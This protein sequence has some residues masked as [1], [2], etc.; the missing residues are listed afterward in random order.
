MLSVLASYATP[1]YPWYGHQINPDKGPRT[2]NAT[3]APL[4]AAAEDACGEH[5]PNVC[6]VQYDDRPLASRPEVDNGL[7]NHNEK[8]C[9]ALSCCTYVFK[10]ATSTEYAPYWAKVAAVAEVLNGTSTRCDYAYW[11][12]ADAALNPATNTQ[13]LIDI[14]GTQDMVVAPD[15]PCLP[16]TLAID[17]G[18]CDR[19]EFNA[20]V[21]GVKNTTEG[22]RLLDDWV[23][24][25]PRDKW[26]KISSG[27][28]SKWQCYVTETSKQCEW[29]RGYYEQGAFGFEIMNNAELKSSI[30]SVRSNVIQSRDCDDTS[31]LIYHFSDNHEA[32]CKCK[33]LSVDGEGPCPDRPPDFS[34]VLQDI[35]VELGFPY[36]SDD[37]GKASHQLT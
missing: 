29:A 14:M 5:D 35:G 6:I 32:G 15:P 22:R 7:L 34:D 10:N 4:P 3:M 18:L 30:H 17:P 23:Q 26:H 28:T 24:L 33:A 27:S 13:Q 19:M 37:S 31:A 2:P 11:L 16:E 9:K 21:W 25:Y 36:D 1:L 8:R 20:G 12:D